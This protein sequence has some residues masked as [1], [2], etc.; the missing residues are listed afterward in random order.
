MWNDMFWNWVRSEPKL[1]SFSMM[2]VNSIKT[3]T[4]LETNVSVT[5]AVRLALFYSSK[6]VNLYFL[7]NGCALVGPLPI[8]T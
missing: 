1:Y 4:A 7:D 5:K 3:G 8:L 6:D 2:R